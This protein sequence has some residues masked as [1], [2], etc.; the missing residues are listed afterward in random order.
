[1]KLVHHFF[2]SNEAYS[3]Y[4]FYIRGS[5]GDMICCVSLFKTIGD[6]DIK[7]HVRDEEDPL[8]MMTMNDPFTIQYYM[9][10]ATIIMDVTAAAAA[11][12]DGNY[13]AREL[14]SRAYELEKDDPGYL[15]LQ[16]KLNSMSM[17]Q[18]T[19]S[20]VK[21]QMLVITQRDKGLDTKLIRRVI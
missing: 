17:E 10:M 7:A 18:K 9:R 6:K 20:W 1:M 8:N 2:Q 3:E 21:N 12:L 19:E 15:E 11:A 5:T 14:L 13:V 16:R 4:E